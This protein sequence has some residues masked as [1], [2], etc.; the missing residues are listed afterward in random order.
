MFRTVRPHSDIECSGWLKAETGS[1]EDVLLLS[2]DEAGSM[3]SSEAAKLSC[4][5]GLRHMFC[6]STA[7]M[8][9]Q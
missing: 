2:Q 6:S 9:K 4:R 5:Q 1:Q 8:F 7:C 3:H